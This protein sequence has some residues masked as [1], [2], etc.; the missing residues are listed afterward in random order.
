MS[1]KINHLLAFES[2]CDDTSVAV[3]RKNPDRE[4]PEVLSFAVQSQWDVHEK[5][6]GV[7]PELASREHLKNILP[8]IQKVLSESGLS[9]AQIDAFAATGKPGLIGCLL[10]GHTTAKTLSYL[11]EKPFISCDHIEGHLM[12]VYLEEKPAFPHLV[13]VVSGGHTSLYIAKEL[14][15]FECIGWALDDAAGEAFDKGAK[16]L[17]FGFPGGPEIDKHAVGADTGR[18][19]FGKVK[20]ADYNF[21]FSGLK[22]ELVRM[23]QR[24]G[25]SL[26]VAGA[27]ASYQN[28]ILNH[29]L[30]KVEKALTEKKLN[31]LVLVGGVA[32]N[33]ELR[34]RLETMK[35]SGLLES[36]HAPRPDYCTDNAAMI[37]LLGL[38]RFMKNETSSLNEDVKST[39]RPPYKKS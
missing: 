18:Y 17:G 7:V 13:A 4:F 38:H 36:W 11:Y 9:L 33:K 34:K 19:P 15:V 37:G 25:T 10:I 23:V 21:S 14:G 35:T 2:S 30:A 12:S 39:S 6:G 16:L 22:S 5:Y 26:D 8:C 28:A 20:V 32:R 3:L 31:R 24:E 1:K 29:L 27:A